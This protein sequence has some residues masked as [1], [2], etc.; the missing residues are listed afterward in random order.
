VGDVIICRAAQNKAAVATKRLV[1]GLPHRKETEI[2]GQT[3]LVDAS[4]NGSHFPYFLAQVCKRTELR[5]G[6][7]MLYLNQQ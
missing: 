4:P 5:E 3:T 1:C 2:M 6:L 7:F